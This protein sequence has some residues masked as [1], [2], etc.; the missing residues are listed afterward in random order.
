MTLIYK[1]CPL[2][3]LPLMNKAFTEDDQNDTQEG[4]DG[5]N[6]D[7]GFVLNMT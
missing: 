3:L 6:T 7:F 5:I 2:A 4:E 1:Q